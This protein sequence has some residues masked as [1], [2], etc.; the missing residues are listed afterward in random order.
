MSVWDDI[1]ERG[2][3]AVSRFAAHTRELEALDPSEPDTSQWY[4]DRDEVRVIEDEAEARMLERIR[5]I[6]E[7]ARRRG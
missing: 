7:A 1:A 3:R 5:E 4:A 2:R 6:S